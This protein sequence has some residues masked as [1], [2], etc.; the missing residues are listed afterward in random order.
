MAEMELR[1]TRRGVAS[2]SSNKKLYT[3]YSRKMFFG[4]VTALV[5]EEEVYGTAKK[6]LSSA[7]T[8]ALYS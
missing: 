8:V 4:E 7:T 3:S 1:V 5:S 2:S 6:S